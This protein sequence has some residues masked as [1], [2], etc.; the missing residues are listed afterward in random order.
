M[1]PVSRLS[2]F[3]FIAV[4]LCACSA[5]RQPPATTNAETPVPAATAANV[6]PSVTPTNSSSA[7]PATQAA[8]GTATKS[9]W[10]VRI[11]P[12]LTT[13]QAVTLQIGTSKLQREEWRVWRQGEAVEFDVPA[14]YLQVPRLY[15]RGSVTP[16]GKLADLCLM[17]KTRGVEHM[18]FDDDDSD[19][20][21]QLKTDIKCR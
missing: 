18:G 21:N 17:Y 19:T 10:W 7:T 15:V 1:N 8:T 3:L 4:T 2:L 20:A 5:R 12:S 14:K 9:G 13:A 6:T 11:H 16:I